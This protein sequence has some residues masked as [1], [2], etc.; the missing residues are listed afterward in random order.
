[1]TEK[2][3]KQITYWLGIVS[4]GLVV[5]LSLQF[6]RAAWSE[7]A[8]GTT[9]PNSNVG[10]PINTGGNIQHKSGVLSIDGAGTAFIVPNGNVGIGTPSPTQRLD[11][12]GDLNVSGVYRKG[13]TAG[14]STT[15]GSGNVPSGFTI[16]GG[17]ITAAGSCTALGGGSGTVTNIATGTGISGGPITTTGTI[18]L[19]NTGS[20]TSCT[21]SS[22]S[23]LYW[24]SAGYLACGTDQTGGAVG[25]NLGNH[26]ATQN[27]VMGNYQIMGGSDGRTVTLNAGNTIK[28]DWS[29]ES[30]TGAYTT[31]FMVDSTDFSLQRRP[32][33]GGNISCP[34]GQA[35]QTIGADGGTSC[36][37]S[38]PVSQQCITKRGASF[39]ND[40]VIWC[41]STHPNMYSCV[42]LDDQAPSSPAS[43][44]CTGDGSC[45]MTGQRTSLGTEMVY[46]EKVVKSGNTYGCLAYDPD[47]SHTAY[48]LD[49]MCCSN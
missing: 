44:G 38:Q 3:S 32:G 48:K 7:P 30:V 5:G 14:V 10:A 21:N 8:I 11:V 17:I 9:P 49:I 22:T 37:T 46:L 18:S 45:D 13:G 39:A 33:T 34:A 29:P 31:R 36:V 26:T 28:L 47:H 43:I 6:V 27:L 35:I 20:F 16:S 40:Q 2:L 1:M 15:C 25:D 12:S 23:K 24:N 4:I 19:N 42:A 41:D